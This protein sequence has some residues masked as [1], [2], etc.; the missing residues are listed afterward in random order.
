MAVSAGRIEALL[1]FPEYVVQTNGRIDTAQHRME[2]S[3]DF[4]SGTGTN[5]HDLVYGERLTLA[6]T[7]TTKDIRGSLTRA[8]GLG[9]LSIVEV[10]AIAV[11]MLSTTAGHELTI[12]NAT[13]AFSDHLGAA[14]HTIKLGPNGLWILMSPIDGYTVGAGTADEI[15][16]DPGA[17]T[18][19]IDWLIVGRSA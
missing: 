4:A 7:P 9:T 17:N 1:N 16:F 8:L 12:G 18:F 15:K 3:L 13:N 19:D 5:Q 6:A 14:T 10:V 2:Y 11:K